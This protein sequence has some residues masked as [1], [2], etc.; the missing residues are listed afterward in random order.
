[1]IV[2]GVVLPSRI[3]INLYKIINFDEFKT[4]TIWIYIIYYI[5][6]L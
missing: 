3:Y 4:A 2:L 6:Y 5:Y 1:M